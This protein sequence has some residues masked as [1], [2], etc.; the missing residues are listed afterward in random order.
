MNFAFRLLL[1][2]AIVV[3]TPPHDMITPPAGWSKESLRNSRSAALG[4]VLAQW[5]SYDR[6][7]EE[8]IEIGKRSSYGFNERSFVEYYRAYLTR[9][10]HRVLAERSMSL[11]NGEHGW[12]MK[13]Q[14]PLEY[15][16][17]RNDD[18]IFVDGKHVYFASYHFHPSLAPSPAAEHAIASLCIPEPVVVKP[19]V[20]PV[21]FVAPR[22]WLLSDPKQSDEPVWPGTLASF[23]SPD[24]P[25]H[26]LMLSRDPGKVTSANDRAQEA[27]AVA[28]MK[29]DNV[30]ETMLAPQTHGIQYLCNDNFGLLVTYTVVYGRQRFAYEQMMLMGSPLYS[31]VYIRPAGQAPYKPA[32]D[33]LRTLCPRN[34]KPVTTPSP[35]MTV[36]PVPSPTPS[37]LR[38]R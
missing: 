33:A 13:S 3:A 26:V 9:S 7:S 5:L 15:G 28:A 34:S 8:Y 31:A 18:V 19:L 4:F 35:S 2:A 23:V 27:A 24:R 37:A 21:A 14:D 1:A 38:L 32:E 16:G 12:F 36:T 29:R 25:D 22:H 6:G 17:E 11:C 10:A 20:L 30:K